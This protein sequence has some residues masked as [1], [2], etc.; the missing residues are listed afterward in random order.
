MSE[1]KALPK[2]SIQQ[3]QH[4]MEMKLVIDTNADGF[5]KVLD[6]AKSSG[7]AIDTASADAKLAALQAAERTLMDAAKSLEDMIGEAQPEY[8]TLVKNMASQGDLDQD[9]MNPVQFQFSVSGYNSNIP[10]TNA[11]TTYMLAEV[12]SVANH[13]HSPSGDVERD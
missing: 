7:L 12:K 10:W 13:S 5:A 9:W 11:P 6:A 4:R 1:V 2:P 3:Y 8:V